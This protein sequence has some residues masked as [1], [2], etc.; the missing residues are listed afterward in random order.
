MDTAVVEIQTELRPAPDVATFETLAGQDGPAG[1]LEPWVLL[2]SQCA[3]GEVAA[4]GERR[5]MA[6]VLTDAMRLYVK[7]GRSRFAGG[8]RLFRETAEWFASRDHGWLLSYENVCDVL[9]IEPDRLRERLRILAS[10][11]RPA[12]IPYDAGRLRVGRGRKMRV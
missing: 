6:A 9:G 12:V 11:E 5:L 1:V 7:H 4:S 2:G 8:Q 3:G 10:A